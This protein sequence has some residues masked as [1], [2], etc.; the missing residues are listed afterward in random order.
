MFK[1][2]MILSYTFF[3][4]CISKICNGFSLYIYIYIYNLIDL[5]SLVFAPNNSHATKII[6]LD[7]HVAEN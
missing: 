2:Y 7:E 3:N 4:L 5:D 6:N 1:L